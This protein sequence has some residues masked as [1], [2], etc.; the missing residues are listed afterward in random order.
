MIGSASGLGTVV[1]AFDNDFGSLHYRFCALRLNVNVH[2]PSGL[3][4]S[5]LPRCGLGGKSSIPRV[6]R[7]CS[8]AMGMQHTRIPIT[9]CCDP[10]DNS[11]RAERR[12]I[13]QHYSKA[14]WVRNY[15][16]QGA[17][18][19]CYAKLSVPRLGT[20]NLIRSGATL[21]LKSFSGIISVTSRDRQ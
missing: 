18:P 7:S 5:Q 14:C 16:W 17:M 13:R 2:R 20:W 10:L 12:P 21:T 8:Q 6:T 19:R 9:R 4:V 11:H 15:L 1:L 3:L